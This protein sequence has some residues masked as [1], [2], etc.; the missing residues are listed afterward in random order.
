M[1]SPKRTTVIWTAVALIISFYVSIE[2]LSQLNGLWEDEVHYNFQFLHARNFYELWGGIAPFLRPVL[3]YAL[4]KWVW[5][6]AWGLTVSERS[7]ALVALF[8]A[9]I[10]LFLVSSAPWT[11]SRLINASA[12][13]LLAFCSTEVAFATE[14]QSYSFISLSS[15]VLVL[16]FIGSCELLSE[17]RWLSS[18]SLMFA[19]WLMA[20]NA[21]FFSWPMALIFMMCY[22]WH[23]STAL[24]LPQVTRRTKQLILVSGIGFVLTLV[25]NKPPLFVLLNSPPAPAASL[26]LDWQRL[27]EIVSQPWA[28]IGLSS[29]LYIPL[30]L[31]AIS[32]PERAKRFVGLA[33]LL[34][35]FPVKLAMVIFMMAKS[36]YPIFDRYLIMFVTPSIF[37]FMI[38]VEAVSMH[39]ELA[40]RGVGTLFLCSVLFGLG[41]NVRVHMAEVPSRAQVGLMKLKGAPNFS[42]VHDF[43]NQIKRENV[44]TLAVTNHC[45]GADVPILYLNHISPN[46]GKRTTVVNY[47]P[48]CGTTE[49][50]F[51]SE[52]SLFLSK[53]SNNGI[54]AV[55]FEKA[56]HT[57]NPCKSPKT[58]LYRVG[59]PE[60]CIAIFKAGDFAKGDLKQTR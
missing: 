22:I 7:L 37:L 38:G 40:K 42:Q 24:D 31:G 3:D 30:A 23:F 36:N 54:V 55:F 6:S 17:K 43:F 15:T 56:P 27:W 2:R 51:E 8:Y 34:S 59:G 12:F 14:A 18:I 48:G 49:Q 44:P 53:H 35:L 20:L 25:V 46:F 1:K 21:H 28:W 60:S 33:L 41:W 52:V 32:H 58:P 45:S 13:L 57:H 47:Y 5:F 29:I 50:E 10:N 19:G 9:G 26:Y 11:R 39:L 16:A 4:R